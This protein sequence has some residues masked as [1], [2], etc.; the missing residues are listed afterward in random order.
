MPDLRAQI[1]YCE[2]QVEC[3]R[4]LLLAHFGEAWD[5][6]RCQRTC[7]V[8]ASHAQHTFQQASA[9]LSLTAT[10]PHPSDPHCHLAH[11]TSV[12]ACRH[13]HLVLA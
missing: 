6:R 12:H 3:R 7:D 10:S 1:A 13:M 8:C 11:A 5:T 9:P 4:A 2:E